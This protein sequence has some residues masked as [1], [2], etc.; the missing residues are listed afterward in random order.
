MQ[1]GPGGGARR[2][3]LL[4]R[5]CTCCKAARL[6]GCK[7]AWLC[8]CR[9]HCCCCGCVGGWLHPLLLLLRCRLSLSVGFRFCVAAAATRPVWVLLP[10]LL[11]LLLT[12]LLSLL[13]T[14][15]LP[16]RGCSHCCCF[17]AA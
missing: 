12:L 11:P 1:A 17:V 13:L 10:C 6:C 16:L 8:G 9:R 3:P 4:L 5:R 7:V 2:T 15:L 14:P